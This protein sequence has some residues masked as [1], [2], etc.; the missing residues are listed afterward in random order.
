[1]RRSPTPLSPPRKWE[2]VAI[3][4]VL[5]SVVLNGPLSVY[6]TPLTEVVVIEV[7]DV[8]QV[9]V[10]S[11]LQEAKDAVMTT[12]ANNVIFLIFLS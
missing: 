11:F 10:L 6:E 12:A 7:V 2:G 3:I 5:F 4:V 8:L 9:Q 1:M